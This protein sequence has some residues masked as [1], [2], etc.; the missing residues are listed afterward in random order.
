VADADSSPH[1]GSRDVVGVIREQEVEMLGGSWAIVE[2]YGISAD[3]E[4]SNLR[5]LAHSRVTHGGRCD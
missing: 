2:A 1:F 3:D 5:P 4:V